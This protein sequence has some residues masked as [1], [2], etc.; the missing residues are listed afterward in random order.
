[1]ADPERTVLLA[2]PYFP[3]DVGG[4]ENYVW[5]LARV[6][7]ARNG[8]Q[9]VVATTARPGE[10][11][12]RG[13][14]PDGVTVHRLRSLAR[15]S[16]TPLGTGWRR[17]LRAIVEAEQVDLVNAHAPVPLFADAAARAC[18]AVPFV[19]TYHTG[20]M[21]KGQLLP[22]AVCA[23]Y[24]RT[25]LAGTAR[26]A[27]EV[28]CSSDYVAA[29]LPRLFGGRATTVSPG[30]DLDR[31]TSG[32]VPAEPRIAFVGSLD[33]ATSYKGLAELLRTAAVLAA[34]R[35]DLRVEVVGSGS[36]AE[37]YRALARQLGIGGQV[38]FSGRLE[39][40]ELAAAY[41]RARV[42][43][44]PTSYDSFPSVLV[45]AMA[46]GRPVVTTPVGG[47]PSLVTD[48]VNGLL[49][50]VGDG[51]ALAGALC[52][53]L[54]DDALAGA[55]GAAGRALVSR[56]LSWDRQCDRTAEVFERALVSGAPA[57]TR[58][59]LPSAR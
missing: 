8:W 39:G 53:V 51:P 59:S 31:F 9:V 36:A 38:V 17:S 25:L 42:L 14:G 28:V 18:P 52:S 41:R 35:P 54:D 10:A 15:V 45:E 55:L 37:E 7:R 6:L 33:R 30:V 47:I 16:N 13:Q 43:A 4:V 34:D 20:R 19:L 48:R 1:M 57:R 27:R 5:H 56:E 3:P 32:P 40:E 29:D 21:R 50:P 46:C 2:A 44:L 12:G 23:L 26:R 11:P 58:R 22:D 24:E 49:V